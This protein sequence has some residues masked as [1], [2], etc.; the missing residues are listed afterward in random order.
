[1][2][3]GVTVGLTSFS[4]VSSLAVRDRILDKRRQGSHSLRMHSC[5]LKKKK[6]KLG[7]RR[8]DWV[9]E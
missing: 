5:L 6:R 3:L 4:S 8:F 2:V 7:N 1:M 9:C